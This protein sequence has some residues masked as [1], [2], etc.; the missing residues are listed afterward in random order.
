VPDNYFPIKKEGYRTIDEMRFTLSQYF[1]DK[2][3][4]KII[5]DLIVPI[6]QFKGKKRYVSVNDTLFARFPGE[7]GYPPFRYVNYNLLMFNHIEEKTFNVV[8]P[9]F[10]YSELEGLLNIQVIQQYVKFKKV[11]YAYKID[12]FINRLRNTKYI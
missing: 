3:T 9:V 8:L 11:V 1:T 4:G 5:T 12:S 7:D 2:I 10:N 6:G